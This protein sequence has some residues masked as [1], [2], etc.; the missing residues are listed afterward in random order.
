MSE[1]VSSMQGVL[2]RGCPLCR[3]STRSGLYALPSVGS[4]NCLHTTV[5]LLESQE[6]SHTVPHW[7]PRH[8][9]PEFLHTDLQDTSHGSR[10]L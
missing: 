8:R 5:A 10:L 3:E 4:P 7:S 6:S 9:L 2:V 1:R